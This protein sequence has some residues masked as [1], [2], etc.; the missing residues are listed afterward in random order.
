VNFDPSHIVWAHS[1]I[2]STGLAGMEIEVAGQTIFMIV[3][4]WL[5]LQL[6]LGLVTARVLARANPR[7]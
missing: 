2:S 1:R 4:L 3:A 7:N 6:P 5:S